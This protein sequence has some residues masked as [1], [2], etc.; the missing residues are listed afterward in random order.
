M[1]VDRNTVDIVIDSG[2]C[3]VQ[4]IPRNVKVLVRDLD[5]RIETLHRRHTHETD[6]KDTNVIK[7]KTPNT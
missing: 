6:T 3:I 5:S 7:I 2:V 1:K 4:H